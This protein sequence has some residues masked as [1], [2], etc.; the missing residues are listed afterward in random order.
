[1]PRQG[2]RAIA[3]NIR[4]EATAI[5]LG[6]I[7]DTFGENSFQVRATVKGIAIAHTQNPLV[8]QGDA[9]VHLAILESDQ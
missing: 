4:G 9:I 6:I 1:M 3:F 7:A 5:I 2:K 8:N